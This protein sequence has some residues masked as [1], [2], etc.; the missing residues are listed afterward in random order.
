MAT[1]SLRD[2]AKAYPA[3][4]T[5]VDGLTLDVPDGELLVLVGPSGCGKT[6]TLRMIAGL[7]SVTRG[8]IAIDGRVL[9]GVAPRDRDV[10]MVFQSC[11]LYPHLDVRRNLAFGL[12][13]R[14]MPR[15][16]IRRRVEETA[17][18]L[19]I[20]H[21]LRRRPASLSGG[22]AQRVALG[23]AIVRRPKVFL[24]DEPLGAID[25]RLR[26]RL[27]REIRRLH[28][29]LRATMIW[30]THDEHE[31]MSLGD[32]VAVMR[33]GRL[34]QVAEPMT[35]YERPANRFVAELIGRPTMNFVAG[36]VTA[37]GEELT[38]RAGDL[39]LPLPPGRQARLRPCAD[40]PML[41]G[42]RPE[43]LVPGPTAGLS[44][45][46]GATAG[47]S[48]SVICTIRGQVTAVE[49]LG[50]ESHVHVNVGVCDLVTRLAGPNPPRVGQAIEMAVLLDH[51]HFFDPETDRAIE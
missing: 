32:R 20:G 31:A 43:H 8:E 29:E 16:E 37:D 10:A 34:Q 5:A 23:R 44:S 27:R 18:W 28:D 19:G 7:E 35:L 38:F 12:S 36:H 46:L 3:G 11:A 13:L 17:A 45:V 51:L 25:A 42:I 15:A 9:S 41:L 30:V 1:L 21:L 22:Q 48:S 33:D 50:T 26:D 49:P 14:R 39:V 4:I 6:T 47:L 2:V 24:L 40:R